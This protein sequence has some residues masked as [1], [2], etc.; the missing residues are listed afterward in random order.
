M[1]EALT[2]YAVGMCRN[3][4]VLYNFQ[5][6]AT[7]AEVRA[8]AVQFVRKVSGMP[9][10]AQANAAAFEEAIDEIQATVTRLLDRLDTKAAPRTREEEAA[11][12]RAKW[13]KREARIRSQQ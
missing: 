5:P 8:A 11:K 12:A 13:Q 6:P 9:K 10:P 7:E 2:G 4:R 3:I 1:R